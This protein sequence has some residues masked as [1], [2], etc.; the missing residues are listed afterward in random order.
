MKK[1]V[2]L[3][4]ILLAGIVLISG[5]IQPEAVCTPGAKQCVGDNLQQCKSDGSAW[6]TIETC[7]YGCDAE[8][9]V[10][11][12]QVTKP[13]MSAEDFISELGNVKDSINEIGRSLST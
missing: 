11:K 13:T 4:A 10:C 3:I 1:D 12:E 5:C 6:E 8:N 7:T 2:V 9:L